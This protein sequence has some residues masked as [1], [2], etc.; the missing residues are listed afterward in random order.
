[1]LEK[2]LV[3]FGLDENEARVFL[4]LLEMGPSG[5]SEV[6][7]RANM[8]RTTLYAVFDRLSEKSLLTFSVQGKR[9]TYVAQP[10]EQVKKMIQ[11]RLAIFEELLP[12]L[13]NRRKKSAQKPVLKYFDGLE[14]IKTVF[15]DSLQAKDEE[16]IGFCGVEALQSTDK[17][18][19]LF[20]ERE[21]I[22]KRKA[23]KKFV[24]LI[25]PENEEGR[26][27][28]E[29]DAEQYRES[30]MVSGSRY[31]FE[32]E[33]HAYDDTVAI[34]SYSKGEEFAV[35]IISKPIANTVKMLFQVIWT[36]AY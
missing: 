9:R 36:V 2:E 34:V 30:R 1:M 35:E 32:C 13:L 27:F 11:D 20:W 31:N 24:R 6:A 14:G 33:I 26:E 12:D 15:L 22:P 28:R 17:A 23:R 7:R 8:N 10:P 18:L 19:R 29:N 4:C 3:R 5:I 16:I 21:Y 25:V